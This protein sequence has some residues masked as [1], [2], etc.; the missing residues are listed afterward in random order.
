MTDDQTEEGTEEDVSEEGA[1]AEGEEDGDGKKKLNKETIMALAAWAS[2]SISF[3]VIV[4]AIFIVSTWITI[5]KPRIPNVEISQSFIKEFNNFEVHDP[6]VEFDKSLVFYTHEDLPETIEK[7]LGDYQLIN[8]W[9]TWCTPCLEEIPGLLNMADRW[10]G[11]GMVVKFV[12]LDFPENAE[13]LKLKMKRKNIP[14]INSLYVKDFDV[15]KK[16]GILGLPTTIL[17]SPRGYMYYTMSG[18]TNW[19]KENAR[20]F[21][22]SIVGK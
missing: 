16:F 2:T 6:P 3:L 12:S 4:A 14:Q 10:Q 13:E 1:G 9:A 5:N 11:K 15:W 7:D 18:D 20:G 22:R 21:I 8:F 19:V 17:V